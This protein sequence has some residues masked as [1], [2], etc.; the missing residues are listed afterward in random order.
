MKVVRNGRENSLTTFV[1]V[2]YAGE[3]TGAGMQVGNAKSEIQDFGSDTLR[4]GICRYRLGIGN[5]NQEHRH[6]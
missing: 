2:L 5:Q 1:T 6:T 4:S 3:K